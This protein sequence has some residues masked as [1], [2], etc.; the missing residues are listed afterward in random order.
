MF[1]TAKYQFGAK[2][3]ANIKPGKVVIRADCYAD[4][5]LLRGLMQP[6]YDMARITDHYC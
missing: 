1:S 3:I 5:T 2:H 4:S 6:H